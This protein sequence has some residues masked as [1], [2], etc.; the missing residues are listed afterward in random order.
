[1]RSLKKSKMYFNQKP[2]NAAD[3]AKD[4]ANSHF[5]KFLKELGLSGVA[6]AWKIAKMCSLEQVGFLLPLLQKLDSPDLENYKQIFAE[7]KILNNVETPSRPD[8][9]SQPGPQLAP[10]A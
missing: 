3:E 10:T 2:F 6:K 8:Q 7:L 5:V 9:L 1:M 4:L